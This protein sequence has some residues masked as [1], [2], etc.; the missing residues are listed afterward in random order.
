MKP[1]IK[2]LWVDAL[3]SGEYQQ[4]IGQLK[5]IGNHFCCLGVLCDLHRKMTG[6]GN[7]TEATLGHEPR[8]APTA[9]KH[10]SVSFLPQEVRDWAGIDEP[11]SSDQLFCNRTKLELD[12]SKLNDTG[13]TFNGIADYIRTN[14]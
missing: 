2:Q 9:A 13:W 11:L 14:V 1:E 6:E 3:D 8:Y 12:T 10:P 7:W 5:T 4:G